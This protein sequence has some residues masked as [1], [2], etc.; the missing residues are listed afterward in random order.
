MARTSALR[1]AADA[2]PMAQLRRGG[3]CRHLLSIARSNGRR[4]SSATP[5]RP[6]LVERFPGWTDGSDSLSSSETEPLAL[7]ELLAHAD[8]ECSERWR[9]LSLGYP[10]HNEGS[11]WLRREILAYYASSAV[12][13]ESMLNV[14]APQEGIYLASRALLRPGDHV[15]ATTPLYQ[16]LGEV[17]RSIGCEVSAW[18]PANASSR[19]RFEPATLD[20]LIRPGSTKLVVAK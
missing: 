16:S 19:P 15:V 7:E 6:F 2:K 17:A 13:D 3:S 10:S 8:D 11:P 14:L 18:R 5:L 4:F 1:F 20:A 12:D 9:T